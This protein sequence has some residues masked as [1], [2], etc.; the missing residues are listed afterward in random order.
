MKD[1]FHFLMMENVMRLRNP[2]KLKFVF[3]LKGSL[4]N[5]MVKPNNKPS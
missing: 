1:E 2:A 5:R 4:V 3:D